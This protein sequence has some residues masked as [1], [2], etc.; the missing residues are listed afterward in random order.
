MS[1][2]IVSRFFLRSILLLLALLSGCATSPTGR[3]QLMM[4]SEESMASM[5]ATAFAQMRADQPINHDGKTNDY[6]TCVA[7]AITRQLPT[8]YAGLDWEVVVFDDEN[9]NAFA[10][11]GGKIGVYTGMLEVAENQAQLATVMGHEVAHVVARHGAERFSQQLAAAGASTAAAVAV[12][13]NASTTEQAAIIALGIGITYGILMPYS[14]TQESEADQ[15]GLDYMAAAGFDP[16]Q[17]VNLWRNM[18]AAGGS[19][20]PEFLS[21]HP[22]HDTRIRNLQDWMGRAQREQG[23]AH[24]A[25]RSPACD[26]R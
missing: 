15:L 11:P 24:A 19:Q 14:R 7:N 18:S 26:G 13:S 5:G 9:A 3:S 8:E 20:P 10:L 22:S 4:V 1:Y 6:V 21:T 2:N 12:G 23:L 16:T 25:G 17:S